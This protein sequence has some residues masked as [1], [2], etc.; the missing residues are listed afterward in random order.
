MERVYE[1]GGEVGRR[2]EERRREGGKEGKREGGK[3]GRGEEEGRGG[4]V[5]HESCTHYHDKRFTL[6]QH[7]AANASEEE[8]NNK[9]EEAEKKSKRL[10]AAQEKNSKGGTLAPVAGDE[11]GER[12]RKRRRGGR[13][14]SLRSG[15]AGAG[16]K[17]GPQCDASKHTGPDGRKF[18][19]VGRCLGGT[20]FGSTVRCL[21]AHWAV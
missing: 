4:G 3:E 7:K 8:K 15:A 14:G 5:F 13:G 6:L 1:S 21:G 16:D 10:K 20:C 9:A 18:P 2:G 12:K 19:A 17:A 11:D